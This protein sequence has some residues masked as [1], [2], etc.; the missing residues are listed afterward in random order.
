MNELTTCAWFVTGLTA[1]L[2]HAG[3]LWR[4]TH[5]LTAWTPVLGVLRLGVV[6]AVLVISALSGAILAAAAGWGLGFVA[7][8]AWFVVSRWNLPIASSIAPPS[9]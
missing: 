7:T 3:L 9:E 1:G 2:L 5:R 4:A 8:G 6:T